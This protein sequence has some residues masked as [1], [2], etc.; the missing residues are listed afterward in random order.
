MSEA[1]ALSED[2]GWVYFSRS[3]FLLSFFF[4]ILSDVTEEQE[5]HGRVCAESAAFDVVAW[6]PF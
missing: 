4:F 2:G 1:T 6:A 3:S 5:M